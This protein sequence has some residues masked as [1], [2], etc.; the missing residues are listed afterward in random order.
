MV[1]LIGVLVM[2]LVWVLFGP[3][4]RWV[5]KGNAAQR[6]DAMYSLDSTRTLHDLDVGSLEYKLLAGGV[7]MQPF[8]FR[9]L[10][11][12]LGLV[13]L[14]AGWA[15][16]PGIPAL[17][18]GGLGAY[19][20]YAWLDDRV[21]GRGRA[22]DRLL[23]VATGRIAAGLLAGGGLSEVL[24]E[25]A[26]SLEIEG[27]NPLSPELLLVSA[28]LLSKDRTQALRDLAKRSPSVSLANLAHL[29]EGYVESGG[30]KYTEVLSDI[31]DRV[32][33]ILIARNR[34]QAKAGDALISART[35]PGVLVVIVVYLS[36][37][38]MVRESL[39]ALPV[40]LILGLTIASMAAGYWI[41]RSMVMEAS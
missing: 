20:P 9:A 17:M 3:R 15:L 26:H 12:G 34:A 19:L 35:I 39:L 18:L 30:G 10:G 14:A 27:A 21:K 22:I 4:P 29:L 37:D 40:Q 5:R 36:Q 28:E 25:T 7:H 16:L 41:M 6:L 23:P 11:V 8:T 32:Q 33:K 24:E 2:I 1:V 38:P 31:A 13:L